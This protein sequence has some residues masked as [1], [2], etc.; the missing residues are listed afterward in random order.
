MGKTIIVACGTGIATSTVVVKKI[1][2]KL[3]AHNIKC[4]IL[5]CKVAE[6]PLKAKGANLIV[7]TT[8]VDGAGD[9]PVIQ[10]T[11]FLTGIGMEADLDKI[12]QIL[13]E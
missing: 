12:V 9:V 5:Q 8:H 3:D 10:S 7:A 4:N 6:V 11:S 13:Q 1:E 2:E